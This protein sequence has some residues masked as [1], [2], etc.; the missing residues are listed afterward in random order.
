MDLV[1][2]KRDPKT[3]KK[4]RTL[5][6]GPNPDPYPYGLE[7]NLDED[8]LQKLGI[9][10]LPA[11]GG[12]VNLAAKAK[13]ASVSSHDSTRG[14]KRRSLSLQITDLALDAGE[15]RPAAGVLYGKGKE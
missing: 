1:S 12:V 10:E 13:I 14:G 7:V 8:S 2:M 4:Q 5:A 11:A 15:R 3:E 9:A 6:E